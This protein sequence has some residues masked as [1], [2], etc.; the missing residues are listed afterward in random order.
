MEGHVPPHSVHHV[1]PPTVAALAELRQHAALHVAP[2]QRQEGD[3]TSDELLLDDAGLEEA[4][5][6]DKL[7]S[8]MMIF[9]I[10][11]VISRKNRI[12]GNL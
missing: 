12:R 10:R 11:H 5:C 3:K 6:G 4:A 8:G 1:A 7:L 9:Y 2:A